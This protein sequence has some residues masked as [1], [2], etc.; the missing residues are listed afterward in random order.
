MTLANNSNDSEFIDVQKNYDELKNY[1]LSLSRRINRPDLHE[2]LLQECLTELFERESKPTNQIAWLK[3]KMFNEC[4]KKN[5][6]FTWKYIRNETRNVELSDR[7]TEHNQSDSSQTRYLIANHLILELP[8]AERTMM[9]M[10][11]KG[12]NNKEI[13]EVLDIPYETICRVVRQT[14]RKLKAKL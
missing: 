6:N 5:S 13:A 4:F 10:R 9:T 8:Y 12:Y 2:D 11:M 1:A 3:S 7:I 14:T